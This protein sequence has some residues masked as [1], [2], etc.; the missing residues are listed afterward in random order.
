MEKKYKVVTGIVE[1]Q[2][3]VDAEVDMADV[4]VD[5]EISKLLRGQDH[6]WKVHMV[7]DP[8]ISSMTSESVWHE[9]IPELEWLSAED[10]A[11]DDQE[12]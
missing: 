8:L 3:I 6:V 1:F 11:D 9:G 7:G 12:E 2:F 5:F 10:E 4:D